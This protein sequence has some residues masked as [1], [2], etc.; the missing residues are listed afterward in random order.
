LDA[1]RFS[2]MKSFDQILWRSRNVLAGSVDTAALASGGEIAKRWGTGPLATS[3]SNIAVWRG[4]SAARTV[5][6][7][8]L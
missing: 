7:V 3:P 4:H 6:T 5:A 2:G 1:A 8:S